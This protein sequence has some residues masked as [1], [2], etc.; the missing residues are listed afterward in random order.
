MPE[1]TVAA[2]LFGA[3]AL[4]GLLNAVAGGGSF[5]TFPALLA[6][7]LPPVAAN[8]TNALAVWPGHALAVYADRQALPAR[9]RGIGGSLLAA[10]A[11]GIAGALLL[12]RVGNERFRA[13]IP[14]LILFATL[15]FAFG[16]ALQR[17]LAAR[18]PRETRVPA[19][20]WQRGG[21]FLLA[22]YGGFFGAGLGVMLMAGLQ[23]MGHEDLRHCN[24]LKNLL[25]TVV[26]SVS[27]I[28]L[29]VSGW[30]S[31]WHAA[32]PFAGAIVGGVAGAKLARRLSARW[33]RVCVVVVGFA[34]FAHYIR[35]A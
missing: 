19:L 25:A 2:L 17:R 29:I 31:P 21:E 15:L 11:G 1:A 27:V 24:L 13:L 33:L 10:L 3:G 28:V 32:W 23:L 18:V 35:L 34:L 30:V 7:G 26:G 8:A 4:A 14:W 9:T 20:L 5:V 12:D 6:T 16:P 22:V